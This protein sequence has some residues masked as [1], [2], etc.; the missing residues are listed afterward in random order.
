MRGQ[1]A[2]SGGPMDENDMD[3]ALRWA[4]LTNLLEERSVEAVK[5]SKQAASALEHAALNQARAS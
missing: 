5:Q 3:Q 4:A 2:E 1:S